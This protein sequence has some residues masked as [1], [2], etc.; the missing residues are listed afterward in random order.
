MAG[1]V[2]KLVCAR[3]PRIL[4]ARVRRGAF[5]PDFHFEHPIEVR[6]AD[7]DA[8]GHVN[9]AVYLTYFE[10]ARAGYYAA[11]MGTPFGTGARAAERTFVIAEAQITYRAPAFFG[12]ILLVGCRFAWASRSSFGVEYVVRAEESVVAPAR[13]IADGTS[14]Q[15]MF[16][17]ER[18][19]VM[20]VPE[21]LL[22]TF[23]KFE[24]RAIPRARTA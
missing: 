14:V 5:D 24:G 10:A 15:V 23:E 11:A 20:R 13:V 19:R 8:F 7:T 21:D 22:E 2:W 4:T 16:D 12:E 17:L 3:G 9:N 6:F 1:C 18:N